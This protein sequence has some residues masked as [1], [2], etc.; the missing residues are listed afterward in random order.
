MKRTLGRTRTGALWVVALGLLT[1]Q[2]AL[3]QDPPEKGM[4]GLSAGALSL[5]DLYSQNVYVGKGSLINF[6]LTGGQLV[7]GSVAAMRPR[8]H[9]GAEDETGAG[10]LGGGSAINGSAVT[11]RVIYGELLGGATGKFQLLDDQGTLRSNVEV[12][13]S[14]TESTLY[15]IA[16]NENEGSSVTETT[17]PY[18]ESMC[19]EDSSSSLKLQ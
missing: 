2:L 10:A 8:N 15:R 19:D 14:A 7:T 9:F 11:G 18:S 4:P 12:V 5:N 3:A 17:L 6:P 13:T 16:T 1:S